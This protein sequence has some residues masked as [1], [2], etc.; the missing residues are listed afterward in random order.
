MSGKVNWRATAKQIDE[1]LSSDID[2][3]Q[4][5]LGTHLAN[6]LS[7]IL[8]YGRAAGADFVEIFLE[9]RRVRNTTIED[10]KVTSISPG[11]GIGAGIRVFK[12][13]RD[14]FYSTNDVSF[15][16]LLAG[17]TKA[18][19]LLELDKPSG[20]SQDVI[21][22][23]LRDYGTLKSKN[24]FLNL[25]PTTEQECSLLLELNRLS[26]AAAAH[27]QTSSTTSLLDWQEVL[28]ASSDGTFARDIRLNQTAAQSLLCVQGD[29]R[30]RVARR[31]GAVQTPMFL[32]SIHSE[33]LVEELATSAADTLKADFVES[34]EMKVVLGNGFGGVIFHEAC[35]H[36]LET[37]ALQNKSTPFADKLE[38]KIAHTAVTAWDEG[39]IEGEFGSI[40]MDDE[41]MPAQRTLLIEGGVL[42]GFL[43]DRMGER[44]TGM[45]RTGSGRRQSYS[46]AAASRM[47]NTFISTG[48]HSPEDL[49]AQLD[50]GLYCKDMGGGSVGP[51]GEFNFAVSEAW[52]VK[53]GKLIKPLKGATLVGSATQILPRIS[54]CATDFSLSPGFCGSVSGRVYTTVGQ[55]HLLVD[56]ITVGGR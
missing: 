32:E 30:T 8:G 50:D 42:K 26:A 10:Q 33:A 39:V 11:I 48:D 14:A 12:G 34:G 55:P 18:L 13:K 6:N 2:I 43:S 36:L 41:G 47:R 19:S 25:I 53:N 3:I 54:A 5:G 17:V 38:E 20:L 37:T 22:E 1:M 27:V 31:R 24:D 52:K 45:P 23:P 7:K 40:D 16:G 46:F 4:G 9:R 49:I 21:L 29:H 35:G 56:Q 51:G 44:R 28:V 15:A